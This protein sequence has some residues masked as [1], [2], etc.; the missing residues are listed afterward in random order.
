MEL[1]KDEILT[2][3]GLV[4]TVIAG[5]FAAFA[6]CMN[7]AVFLTKDLSTLNGRY[8]TLEASKL[9]LDERMNK[10][11]EGILDKFH[12]IKAEIN[13]IRDKVQELDR[14][15]A[16]NGA[17]LDTVLKGISKIFDLLEKKADKVPG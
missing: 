15:T 4:L 5:M 16:V 6:F 3:L 9:S 12:E 13:P 17:K 7:K 8:K 14:N 11:E 10:L 2:I 1:T